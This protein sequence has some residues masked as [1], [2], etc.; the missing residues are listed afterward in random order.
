M[1]KSIQGHKPSPKALLYTKWTACIHFNQ[2]KFSRPTTTSHHCNVTH[3]I[4]NA[5]STFESSWTVRLL[6]RVIYQSLFTKSG[7]PQNMMSRCPRI[8]AA[9]LSNNVFSGTVNDASLY[10][11]PSEDERP[12]ILF[13]KGT[14]Q[15]QQAKVHS[16]S[17]QSCFCVTQPSTLRKCYYTGSDLAEMRKDFS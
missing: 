6:R 11:L 3:F 16:H 7:S 5:R 1:I 17:L 13:S 10:V 9:C 12:P 4:T 2:F 15:N 14:K 8:Y